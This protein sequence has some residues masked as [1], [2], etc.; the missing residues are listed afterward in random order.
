[1]MR[2]LDGRVASQLVQDKI[3]LSVF[4]PSFFILRCFWEVTAQNCPAR[5]GLLGHMPRSP[6]TALGMFCLGDC[7]EV[8]FVTIIPCPNMHRD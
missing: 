1:M 6:E 4:L 5:L 8:I 7:F 3:V 2:T